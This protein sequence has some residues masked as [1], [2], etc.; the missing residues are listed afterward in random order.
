MP[1]IGKL[2]LGPE[3][4]SIAEYFG[5]DHDHRKDLEE[6]VQNGP[7]RE[8]PL[9]SHNAGPFETWHWNAET[10][11]AVD[12]LDTRWANGGVQISRGQRADDPRYSGHEPTRF[13]M[14]PH[15]HLV[16]GRPSDVGSEP[17]WRFATSDDLRT[18]IAKAKSLRIAC[19]H[20]ERALAERIEL[21]QK[22]AQ[23]ATQHEP[24]NA[25][26]DQ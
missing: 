25:E 14:N 12:E 2:S 19:D 21:E 8:E 23:R 26:D 3:S 9:K 7:E 13:M 6:R 18:S 22:R 20:V 4:D 11:A 16:E 1:Y 5:R 24:I 15:G 10:P 17:G